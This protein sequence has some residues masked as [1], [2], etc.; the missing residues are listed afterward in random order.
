MKPP[1]TTV[2][3]SAKMEDHIDLFRKF[4]KTCQFTCIVGSQIH[5]IGS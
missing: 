5:L 2:T 3:G 4:L 1:K